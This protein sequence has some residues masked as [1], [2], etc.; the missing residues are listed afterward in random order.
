MARV[1]DAA[2]GKHLHLFYPGEAGVTRAAC[3]ATHGAVLTL[4]ADSK[5]RTWD[6]ATGSELKSLTLEPRAAARTMLVASLSDDTLLTDGR[7]G[8]QI[9]S[10]QTG[11]MERSLR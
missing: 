10:A 1:W 3:F 2:D 8:F 11:R 5:V 7:L 4:G 6:P 9:R